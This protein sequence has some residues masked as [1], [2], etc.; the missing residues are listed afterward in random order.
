MQAG[1]WFSVLRII[2]VNREILGFV[3]NQPVSVSDGMLILRTPN[4]AG[5]GVPGLGHTQKNMRTAPP[6]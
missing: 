6:V 1:E 4:I 2:E 5:T 3:I